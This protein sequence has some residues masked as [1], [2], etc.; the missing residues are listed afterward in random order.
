MNHNCDPKS[1]ESINWKFEQLLE[2]EFYYLKKKKINRIY[3]TVF[4]IF[5]LEKYLKKRFF[6]KIF[7][8]LQ[9]F[10]KN[11]NGVSS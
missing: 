10:P 6:L 5:K 4:Q 1:F 3:P 8:I 9:L 7:N 11:A 2:R